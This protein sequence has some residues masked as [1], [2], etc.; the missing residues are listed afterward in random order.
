MA[1]C[2]SCLAAIDAR[3]AA[4]K[5]E[6][7]ESRSLGYPPQYYLEDA[8]SLHVPDGSVIESLSENAKLAGYEVGGLPGDDLQSAVKIHIIEGAKRGNKQL[9]DAVRDALLV[10]GEAKAAIQAAGLSH[11]AADLRTAESFQLLPIL[12]ARCMSDREQWLH[13][14]L[15]DT[16]D[17]AKGGSVVKGGVVAGF[18][19]YGKSDILRNV[20]FG[21]ALVQWALQDATI[22]GF[23]NHAHVGIYVSD[24]M[25]E[26]IGG[27]QGANPVALIAAGLAR[28]GY[29]DVAHPP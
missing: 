23:S 15:S 25:D 20:V 18:K 1:G 14:F 21:K 5:E 16:L 27:L 22:P 6:T 2:D 4:L 17:V 3:R 29:I 19:G 7:L 9:V 26:R 28:A 8:K 24:P 11:Q 10:V 13:M 12:D